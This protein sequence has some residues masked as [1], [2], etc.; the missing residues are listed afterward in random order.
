[1]ITHYFKIAWRNLFKDRQFAVLNLLGLSTGL[2]CAIF[3][4]LWADDELHV[5]KFNEKDARLYQVMHTDNAGTATV[6]NT[7]GLLAK[8]LP[9][10]MPE[11]QYAAA[12]IPSNWFSNKGLIAYNN[13][14]FRADVQFVSKDYF[15]AFS[16][17][18]LTG[19]K[20][21]LF[22]GNDNIAISSDLA[23]KLFNTTSDIV[24]RTIEWNQ[25]GFSGR[26]QVSGIFQ[27]LPSNSTAQFDILF[28]YELFLEKNPKLQNWGNNDPATYVVLKEGIAADQFDKKIAGFIHTKNPQSTD[29]LFVQ[30][31]SDKYL[32]NR[33]ENGRPAGGRIEYVELF[34]IIAIFI[35][36][37][38]CINF[39]NLS[40]ARA[41]RR[42][43]EIG[44]KKV[45]GASRG[46][47]ILQ[48]MGESMLLTFLSLAVTILL[49]LAFLPQFNSITAK[50]LSFRPDAR[51][52]LTIL[53]IAVITGFIAGSYPALYL[54]RFNPVTVLKGKLNTSLGELIARKSLVI[55]Q[56]TL[57]VI[58]IVSVLVV[59]KQI[60]LVQTKNLG[61][62]RDQVLYFEKG[63]QLSDDKAY[64]KPG[65][66]YEKELQAFISGVK[67]IPGV[68]N[69]S[70]FRHSITNR[71]GGTTAVNWTGKIQDDQTQF[72]DIAAG[73]D[74]I[75]TLGIKMKEGRT[76]SRDFGMA[77]GTVIFNE[78][79]IK[80][81]GLKDP[82]GKT[83]NIW[84][85]DRQIIGV[86]N[87][88]H[89]EPLY[90]TIK[91]CFFD[92]SLNQR[93]SKI[94]VKIKSGTEKATIERLAKFY[95]DYTGEPIDYKFMD[96]DY[97]A[98]YASENRVATLSGYFAGI[99]ILIS[100]LGLF[101]LVAFTAQKRKQEIGIRKVVGATVQSVVLM[102]SKDFLKQVFVAILIAFPVAW[103]AMHRWLEGF[104]YRVS[105]GVDVFVI[106]AAA[107]ILITLL[108]ISYQSFKAAVANPVRSLRTE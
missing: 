27:K 46:A 62:N 59:Y 53:L 84:G 55:F 65:G 106:S 74:F 18:F 56:F 54:S 69:V 80:A 75:E 41:A 86:T 98:L 7:P 73:Y 78:S 51:L 20:N 82:I 47:L 87:D 48:H 9:E 19:D 14:R 72:T 66:G 39:M 64:Y 4:F 8:A 42:V 90:E 94:V 68:L 108:T 29:R 52:V 101:G 10:E 32:H 79:A 44:V 2:A 35:L 103:W 31:F 60:G 91:P 30:H 71:H 85:E 88:F 96:E 25:E 83:V 1:M 24:G 76:F 37:I 100:C 92:F 61:Y 63:G 34:S 93:V 70:N 11:V 21:A 67:T 81:M 57:S 77:K 104:A 13:T 89:F 17:Y 3:I 5:N 95:K 107:V 97:Q 50:H 102:L 38:A 40:T 49:V 105:I 23:L 33:Y 28:N 22:A 26:Y 36:V 16:V 15:N 58:L 99:A 6:E 43:K 45:M 12:V